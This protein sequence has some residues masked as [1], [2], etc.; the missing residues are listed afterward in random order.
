[1]AAARA[2]YHAGLPPTYRPWLHLAAPFACGAAVIAGCLACLE[3]PAPWNMS[4]VPGMWI[5]S[6]ALERRF[7]RDLLHRRVPPLQ[8]LRDKHTVSHHSLHVDGAMQIA[9][10][11]DFRSI[12]FPWWAPPALAAALGPP[13]L[14]LGLVFG[15]DVGRHIHGRVRQPTPRPRPVRRAGGLDGER[16]QITRRAWRARRARRGRA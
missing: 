15:G 8:W 14:L 4:V 1:M 7:H 5:A 13:A 16:W 10:A 9:S 11:R 3:G 6:L 2:R 12:L